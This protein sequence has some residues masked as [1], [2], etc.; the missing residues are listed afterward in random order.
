MSDSHTRRV[1]KLVV[2]RVEKVDVVCQAGQ[3]ASLPKSP[4]LPMLQHTSLDAFP[5]VLRVLFAHTHNRPRASVPYEIR[6]LDRIHERVPHSSSLR[7]QRVELLA[8]QLRIVHH[9]FPR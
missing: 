6:L 8:R 9:E 7:I 4:E 2:E 5:Q 3:L 1:E